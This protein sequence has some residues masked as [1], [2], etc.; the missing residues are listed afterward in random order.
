[1]N[2]RGCCGV[3]FNS[4]CWVTQDIWDLRMVV[5]ETAIAIRVSPMKRFSRALFHP[6]RRPGR[7]NPLS[8]GPSP[9]P[10]ILGPL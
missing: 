2:F 8:L 5:L 10:L 1:M 7:L 3:S 6:S 9:L 4:L